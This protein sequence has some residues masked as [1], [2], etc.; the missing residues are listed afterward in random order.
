MT[1]DR[2][3]LAT[4]FLLSKIPD[5]EILITGHS[6]GASIATLLASF[7]GHA[8]G[9]FAS[10]KDARYKAYVFA[11]AKP[12]NDHYSYDFGALY[13]VHGQGWTVVSTQGWVP[14]VPFTL[15]F[16]SDINT[17]NPLK[18]YDGRQLET[19]DAGLTT[20]ARAEVDTARLREDVA[21]RG[22]IHLEA[23]SQRLRAANETVGRIAMPQGDGHAVNASA[24]A[25]T[26]DGFLG[27]LQASLNYAYA[28]SLVPLFATPG[29]N[30]DDP[31]DYFWQHHLGNYWIY[32][33]AQYGKT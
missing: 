7:V 23:V 20:L 19:A 15:Q 9:P 1:T 24:L 11:P 6:Q 13:G 14:Q 28:G 25:D 26:L 16:P 18:P 27:Y 12:G 3:L 8:D 33:Q 5:A 22:K 30:P 17:P 4:L 32:M 21:R 2:P 29:G 10:I 31:A